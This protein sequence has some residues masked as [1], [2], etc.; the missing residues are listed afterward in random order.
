MN[1]IGIFGGTF[2]PVHIG[3]MIMAEN[4]YEQFELDEVWMMPSGN[5]PHKIGEKIQTG[6]VRC[7]MLRLAIGENLHIKCTDFELKREGLIYTADTLKLLREK[8][9]SDKFYFLLGE[10]SLDSFGNWYHPERIVKLAD[11][12]V[13]VRSNGINIEEKLDMFKKTFNCQVSVLSVPFIGVSSSDIRE[14]SRNG[15]TIK[16]MVNESVEKFIYD[17]NLYN[18]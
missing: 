8:Y 6:T 11:I 15:A 7:E 16:Y 14:R 2:N 13:A 18:G 3:H 10:D 12:V 4:F 5:P 1:K 9:S 17:N